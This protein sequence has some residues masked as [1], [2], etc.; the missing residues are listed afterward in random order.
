[1]SAEFTQKR[2]DDVFAHIGVLKHTAV[3]TSLVM[4]SPLLFC[5]LTLAHN[6]FST[7]VAHLT[8]KNWSLVENSPHL[9][10]VNVCRQS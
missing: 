6:P 8:S 9:W 1:M 7:N 2:C 5:A 10:M 4:A 3:Q